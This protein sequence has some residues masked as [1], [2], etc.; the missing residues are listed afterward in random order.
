M[1]VLPKYAALENERRFLVEA[2]ECPDLTDNPYRLIEDRY[3]DHARLRLRAVT[4]SATGVRELKFC[5]K[6]GSDDPVSAPITNLYLTEDEHAVLARLPGRDIRKR[7]YRVA[8]EGRA[9]SLDVFEGALAGLILCEAEGESR[10]AIL[11]VKF[12]P[13]CLR[14]VTQE[15]AFTGG[16][17]S[18][19]S[20]SPR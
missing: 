18:K 6:Y 13:W 11:A 3:I 19:L 15:P 4:H 5:K 14:E 2:A 9:F 1:A 7:R 8:H 10:E 17:L 16:R 12:P 20:S